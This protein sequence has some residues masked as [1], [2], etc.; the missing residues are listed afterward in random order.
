MATQTWQMSYDEWKEASSKAWKAQEEEQKQ[1]DK[2]REIV[3]QY[4][5]GL[6]MPKDSMDV[7]IRIIEMYLYKG[8]ASWYRAKEL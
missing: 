7:I 1:M 6:L 5:D 8:H 4:N 3:K 2:I